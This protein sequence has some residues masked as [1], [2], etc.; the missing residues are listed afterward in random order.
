[1]ET[2]KLYVVPAKDDKGQPQYFVH[3]FNSAKEAERS[4]G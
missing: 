3:K 4:R 2:P 1:V